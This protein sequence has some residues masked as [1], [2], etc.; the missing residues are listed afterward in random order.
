MVH[1]RR[2]GELRSEVWEAVR[3]LIRRASTAKEH[4]VSRVG[5]VPDHIHMT[6]G[7]RPDEAPIGV[8]LSYMNNIA[9]V[10]GM[11]PIFTHSCYVATFGEYDLGAVRDEA[12]GTRRVGGQNGVGPVG[13][14]V[15]GERYGSSQ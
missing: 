13:S 5:I 10:R 11:E 12:M 14:R 15:K 4:L 1:D 3:S 9:Y 8:A 2:Q 7:F 6:L